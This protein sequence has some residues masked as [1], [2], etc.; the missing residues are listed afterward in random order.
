MMEAGLNPLHDKPCGLCEDAA[1]EAT[2]L[3]R[4][5]AGGDGTA[6]VELH[7]AWAP[8]LLGIACRMTA[9]R[10]E[11]DEVLRLT[12]ERMWKRARTFDPHLAPPFVWAFMLMRE[13]AMERHQQKR[14]GKTDV[15]REHPAAS[16]ERC[17]PSKALAGE[18]NRR[19]RAAMGQLDLEES[20]CLELAVFLGYSR[21]LVPPASVK[22][23]L[24]RALE[25]LR[26]QLS[27]H[28][29]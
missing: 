19:L 24:R 6:L 13:L 23:H 17:D 11:A 22:N 15:P 14:T 16:G 1:G 10:R 21:P 26:N 20:T 12:F 8:V 3:I 9:D 2:A 27:L 7:G 4:R 28:E 18:D 29:L 5:M 25:T